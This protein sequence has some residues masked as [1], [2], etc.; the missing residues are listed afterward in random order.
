MTI[1]PAA[2]VNPISNFFTPPIPSD[3]Q[4]PWINWGGNQTSTPAF[5]VHPR[6]EQEALDT[7]RYAALRR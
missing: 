4:K 1:T 3:T 5:T 6:N 7:V 2:P